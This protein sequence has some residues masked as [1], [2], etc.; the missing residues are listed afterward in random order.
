MPWLPYTPSGKTRQMQEVLAHTQNTGWQQMTFTPHLG[1]WSFLFE[2]RSIFFLFTRPKMGKKRICSKNLWAPQSPF[3]S[4]LFLHFI[5]SNVRLWGNQ[6]ME[7][8]GRRGEGRTKEKEREE[9]PDLPL[10]WMYYE[11]LGNYGKKWRRSK[12]KMNTFQR[13]YELSDRI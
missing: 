7:E 4:Y 3:F 13:V 5:R 9:S 1:F 8:R 10:S 12:R 6:E 2:L 11:S